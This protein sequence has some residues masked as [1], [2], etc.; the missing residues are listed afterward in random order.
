MTL[1]IYS[2]VV[3]PTALLGIAAYA[4]VIKELLVRQP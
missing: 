4:S 3:F 1:L 2:T